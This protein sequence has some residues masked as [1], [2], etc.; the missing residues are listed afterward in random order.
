MSG[1]LTDKMF[2]RHGAPS[3]LSHSGIY[4]E[5]QLARGFITV[6]LETHWLRMTCVTPAVNRHSSVL[7][8]RIS[9]CPVFP[10]LTSLDTGVLS[11]LKSL[12]TQKHP[13]VLVYDLTRGA[14]NFTV[15]YGHSGT[16]SHPCSHQSPCCT[17]S[18]NSICSNSIG[19][20]MQAW[21]QLLMVRL[22][23]RYPTYLIL[24]I[25]SSTA[26]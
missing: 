20:K 8:D 18:L 14:V 9:C 19:A 3:S 11:V 22:N 1:N 6:K 16:S 21:I 12:L 13:E 17:V 23:Y 10:V 15:F 2:R 4:W 24:I 25:F 7:V 5:T 26:K